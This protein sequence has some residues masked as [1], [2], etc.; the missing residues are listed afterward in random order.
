MYALIFLMVFTSCAGHTTPNMTNVTTHIREFE[1]LCRCKNFV[2]IYFSKLK[3]N[4]VGECR[5][6]K[7][8]KLFRNIHLDED[9]WEKSDEYEREAL[10]FHELGHCVLDREHDDSIIFVDSGPRPKSL[11]NSFLFSEYKKN[12]GYYIWEMFSSQSL[13]SGDIDL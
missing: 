9:Y 8:L 5:W 1:K 10:I 2:P 13:M 3:G 11:M 12:R 6:F 7:G 4:H